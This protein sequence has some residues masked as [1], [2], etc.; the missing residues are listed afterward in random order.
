MSEVP[1]YGSRLGV[2]FRVGDRLWI[3]VR[4]RLWVQVRVPTG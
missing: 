1:L 3:Q 4:N 2:G